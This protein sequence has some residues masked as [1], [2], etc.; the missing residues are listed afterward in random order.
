VIQQTG[1][2]FVGTENGCL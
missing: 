2:S 1:N